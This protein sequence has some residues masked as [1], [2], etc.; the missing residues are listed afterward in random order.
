MTDELVIAQINC[1]Y[2]E[3]AEDILK[4]HKLGKD[5]NWVLTKIIKAG[6]GDA[7]MQLLKALNAADADAGQSYQDLYHYTW[8]DLDELLHHESGYLAAKLD[9]DPYTL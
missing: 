9:M 4:A 8:E 7:F 2:C 1:T 6:K 5:A 3:T